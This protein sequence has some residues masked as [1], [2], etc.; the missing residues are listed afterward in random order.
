MLCSTWTT[1][2]ANANKRRM[3][4]SKRYTKLL[5]TLA[6]GIHVIQARQVLCVVI[7]HIDM[8]NLGTPST[9]ME[10]PT[11]TLGNL[12]IFIGKR[13]LPM[14]HRLLMYHRNRNNKSKLNLIHMR[15][16]NVKNDNHKSK[17]YYKNK[18]WR[19]SKTA[20]KKARTKLMTC[21]VILLMTITDAK[22]NMRTPT[23]KKDLGIDDM[24]PMR[25]RITVIVKP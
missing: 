16:N 1:V 25:N 6:T 21:V 17:L 12:M 23:M 8:R 9:I 14:R 24:T 5:R 20:D 4:N 11:I 15:H 10:T 19:S 3:L 22:N 13:K 7:T 18:Q 2:T